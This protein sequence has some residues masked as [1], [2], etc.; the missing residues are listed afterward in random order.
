M[1]T[2]QPQSFLS[3]AKRF[4]IFPAAWLYIAST[5]GA[6]FIDSFAVGPQSHA[7]GPGDSDWGETVSEL[8]PAQALGGGRRLTLLADADAAFR[9][10]EDGSFS[11]VLSGSTPGSLDIQAAVVTPPEASSYEP[12]VLLDYDSLPADWSVCDRIVVRF[13]TPP[14]ED[15][16]VQTSLNSGG[17][18]FWSNTRV[19]AGSQSATILFSELSG[20]A[21]VMLSSVTSLRLQWNLPAVVFLALRDIQVIGAS[22]PELPRLTLSVGAGA[23]LSW[24]TNAVG[25][26]LENSTNGVTSFAT[27]T[28]EPGIT[29]TNYVVTLPGMQAAEFFRLHKP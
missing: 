13:S 21:P 4:V 20:S 7:L 24:P 8:D 19:P 26:L 14:T 18:A 3:S 6:A 29:G 1:K 5:A 25:F 23:T 2:T 27:V 9:A 12:A 11:A 17:D 15:V 10:L 28:N 16:A 22:A